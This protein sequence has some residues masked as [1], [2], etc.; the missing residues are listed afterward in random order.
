M[1]ESNEE[2][3]AELTNSNIKVGMSTIIEEDVQ[4]S[5]VVSSNSLKEL[6]IRYFLSVKQAIEVIKRYVNDPMALDIC[7]RHEANFE[8]DEAR[9]LEESESIC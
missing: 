1:Q 7:Y 3:L 9:I 8:K 6:L 4:P 5:W 2:D